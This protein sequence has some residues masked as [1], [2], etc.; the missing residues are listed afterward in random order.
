MENETVRDLL[1]DAYYKFN[2]S[3]LLIEPFTVTT[4]CNV[5]SLSITFRHFKYVCKEV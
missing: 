4:L 3:L 2:P 1:T 5:L